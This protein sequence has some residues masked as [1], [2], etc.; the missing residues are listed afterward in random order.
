[1]RELFGNPKL[2]M[3]AEMALDLGVANCALVADGQLMAALS[4]AASQHCTAIFRFHAFAKA[5]RFGALTVV[6]LKCSLRH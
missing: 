2:G 3:F 1:M 4:A 5:M 6:G